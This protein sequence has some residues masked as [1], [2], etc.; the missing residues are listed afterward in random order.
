[1][2]SLVTGRV[3]R[4]WTQQQLRVLVGLR[5]AAAG[6]CSA[7]SCCFRHQ[8]QMHSSC[9]LSSCAL[10]MASS[11]VRPPCCSCPSIHIRRPQQR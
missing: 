3:T 8:Q 5:V 9:S 2:L 10:L 6:T 1:M 11:P 4:V 7:I